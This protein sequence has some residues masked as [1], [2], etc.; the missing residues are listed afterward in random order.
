MDKMKLKSNRCNKLDEALLMQLTIS[1]TIHSLVYSITWGIFNTQVLAQRRLIRFT[2][3]VLG[4]R[5]CA[6]RTGWNAMKLPPLSFQMHINM[7]SHD[8][9]LA[10][11]KKKD[12]GYPF[13]F[14]LSADNNMT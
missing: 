14:K 3:T 13:N 2:N 6:A 11:N 9:Y 12:L 1:C 4:T 8:K 10:V 7:A 5:V